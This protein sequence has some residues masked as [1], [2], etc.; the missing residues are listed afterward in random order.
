VRAALRKARL[1]P[2][3]EKLSY[4]HRKEHIN[5]IEEAKQPQT[6][7]RRIERMIEMLSK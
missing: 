3:F 2:A 1:E 4:T 7:A 6:R 5:A